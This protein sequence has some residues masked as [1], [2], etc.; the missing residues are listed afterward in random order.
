M[1][2]GQI[3]VF[4]LSRDFTDCFPEFRQPV[5]RSVREVSRPGVVEDCLTN[6]GRCRKI[7]IGGC[8]RD[9][10]IRLFGPSM[11]VGPLAKNAAIHRFVTEGR[12][13]VC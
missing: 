9:N 2:G 4:T 11:I 8:K 10:V 3:D 13:R 6:S 7:R 1:I 12:Y 5:G